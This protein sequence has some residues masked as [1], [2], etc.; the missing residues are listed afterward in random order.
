MRQLVSDCANKFGPTCLGRDRAY[1]RFWK[2]ESCPGLFVEHN[3]DEIGECLPG[4]SKL[5]PNARPMDEALAIEKV[6]EI[7]DAREKEAT[8]ASGGAETS[9]N[10]S[11]SSDKENELEESKKEMTKTYSKTQN[12]KA[13]APKQTVLATMNG[14]LQTSSTSSATE[15]SNEIKKEEP[16]SMVN[17]TTETALVKKDEPSTSGQEIKTETETGPKMWGICIPNMDI[18]TVHSTILPKTNWSYIGSAEVLDRFIDALNPRGI[19]ESELKDKLVSERDA[20]VKDL[21]SFNVQIEPNLNEDS[22]DKEEDSSEDIN[23]IIDLALRDQIMEIEEKIFFGTLGTLKIHDRQ[24]WQK[25]IQAGGY[26]KQCDALTWGGKS[27]MNT[28]FESRIMSADQSR[29]Q[30]RAGSP[31]RESNRGSGEFFV[32]RQSNKVRGLA[33]AMLQVSQMLANKYFKPPLGKDIFLWYYVHIM[34][35]F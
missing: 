7:L 34:K 29:D 24:A 1:R 28:P 17:G 9:A 16:C 15:N 12:S 30:S 18:C 19:R 4:G 27:M 13:L 35:Q 22:K 3:D 8:S 6:K 5:D 31:D 11:Q 23:A 32:K 20:I 26:D 10:S 2:L 21:K 33:C 14:T 25:A